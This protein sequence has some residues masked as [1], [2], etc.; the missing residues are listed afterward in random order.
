LRSGRYPA[1]RSLAPDRRPFPGPARQEIAP[2][3]DLFAARAQMGIS[4]AFHIV[5]A[6][7]GMALP[8]LLLVSEGLWLRT[9]NPACLAL[10]KRWSKG[11]AILFAV[12]AV[13]G[14]ILSFELGLLWPRFM[15]FAGGIFGLPFSAEGF[16]FFVEAIFLGLYL[17]GWSRLSP[18]QHWLCAVPIAVSGVL[19]AVFVV[20]A[21]AWMNSPTGFRMVDGAAVDVDPVAAMFN[22]AWFQQALHMVLAAFV[23]TGFGVAG[24]YAWGLLRGRRDAYHRAGLAIAMGLAAVAAPLQFVSGDVSA[25]WVA[26]YQPVKLAALE[27]QFATEAGAPLR[28]GGLP[29]VATGQTRWAL[30]IPR[31]LSLLAFHDPNAVVRGLD[32]WPPADRPNPVPVHLAFQAMVG[33]GT[34]L[35]LLALWYWVAAWR[36]RGLPEGRWL[37]RAI[38]VATPL[39]FVAIEA[40]W[41]VTEVGRQPWVVYGVMRTADGVTPVPNQFIALGG[42]VIV[43]VVLAIAAAGL[44]IRLGRTPPEIEG[45]APEGTPD[46]GRVGHAGLAG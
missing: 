19:S 13:S 37:L 5:L 12:G 18:V 31:G 27:G 29:D 43:Y 20:A 46:A 16:A 45:A 35:L 32:E 4:L 9:G 41:T 17:Y 21:N 42:F 36:R 10:A 15:A 8:V 3:T 24:L 23:A 30:E 22:P 34:A 11:F 1:D 6:V 14:T 25:R 40:G 38:A 7:L 28:I 44:L 2:V 39:G 26:E 33:V